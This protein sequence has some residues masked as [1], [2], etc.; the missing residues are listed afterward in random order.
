[1]NLEVHSPPQGKE[2]FKAI[3]LRRRERAF[4]VWE[5]YEGGAKVNEIAQFFGI[6]RRMVFKDL[7]VARQLHKEAVQNADGGEL[8]GGEIAFW[9]QVVR[10]A[11]R[12]YQ[13]AQSENAKIGFLRVASEARA[14]LQKLYQETGLITTVPTRISLEEANPFSDPEFRKKYIALLK[15]AREKGVAI[16]G[17]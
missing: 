8:L 5:M 6:S 7:R 16:Y 12:D 2:Q 11:M 1:M 3:S 14:K 17:L 4:K 10:Q 9:Q 15:E 13:M